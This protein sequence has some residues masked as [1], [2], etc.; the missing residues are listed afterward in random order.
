MP[1]S[2]VTEQGSSRSEKESHTEMRLW[3]VGLWIAESTFTNTENSQGQGR[4]N[5]YDHIN[6]QVLPTIN[7]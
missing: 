3:R 6:A 7:L 4:M 5:D 2:H 1:L